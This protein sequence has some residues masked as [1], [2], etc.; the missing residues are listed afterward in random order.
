MWKS[1][2][3]RLSVPFFFQYVLNDKVSY[4]EETFMDWEFKISVMYDIAKVR[5][6]L[7]APL[8]DDPLCPSEVL[9][10]IW[11]MIPRLWSFLDEGKLGAICSARH[12]RTSNMFV[13]HSFTI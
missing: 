3:E 9:Y 2:K 1:W 6:K 8:M 4:P 7:R 13:E 10:C 12:K 5:Q 11:P